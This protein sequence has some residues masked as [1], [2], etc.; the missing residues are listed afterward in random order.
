MKPIKFYSIKKQDYFIKK[1]IISSIKKIILKN[2]FI[3][4]KEVDKF[5]NNFSKFC[6][7][8]YSISCANGT[9]ALI[10]ALKSLNLNKNS[11]V[12]LPAMTY[13]STIFAVIHA[14]LKPVLVDIEKNSPLIDYKR[15]SEKINKNTSVIMPVHLYGS[16]VN[17]DIIKNIIKKK[18][19]D[20]KII[21]DCAQAH[22][23]YNCYQ[24]ENSYKENCCFK[25]S[26]VGSNSTIS[27]FSLYPGKNLGAYGDAGIINTN[28]VNI[29]HKIRK[30]RNLGFE[31]KFYYEEIGFNSRLDTIQSAI[32][33]EKIKFLDYL[34][35]KRTLIA[36]KYFNKI[37]NKKI[38]FLN[39]SKGS[40]FHQFVIKVK[41]RTKLCKFLDKVGI[42]YGF[43]YPQSINKINSLKNFFKNQKFLN[44]EKLARECLS[45][46]IDPMLNNKEIDYIIEKLNK[47]K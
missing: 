5:E 38:N 42:E 33:N 18:K 26:K 47:F 35:R 1:K 41:E 23:A 17:L 22:G 19:K 6:G 7:S 13:V 20:I 2:D 46:P 45:I 30:L 28:N 21:D 36:Y 11:E 15:I 34:N 16:V 24:C 4:G 3:L 31:K 44:A 27:A 12:I 40:V 9:D 43:H 29:Y 8:N 32:L 14:N 25:G 39:Y 37:S 10:I